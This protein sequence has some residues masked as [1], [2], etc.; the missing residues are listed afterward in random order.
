MAGT[1]A[2]AAKARAKALEAGG[3]LFVPKPQQ[4]R[5]EPVG[6]AG[7]ERVGAVGPV[8]DV[9]SQSNQD[10]DLNAASVGALG[11]VQRVINGAVKAPVAVRVTAAL[12]IIEIAE[13]RRSKG[14]GPDRGG[15]S[16][17]VIARLTGALAL[18]RRTLD[19]VP[20]VISGAEVVDAVTVEQSEQ[21]PES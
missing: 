7:V 16:D 3:A 21:Q 1:A 9:L 19:A 18:R 4:P 11:F 14:G 8:L 15:L 20:A 12:R 6:S 17:A 2:G 5:V 13:G 10:L